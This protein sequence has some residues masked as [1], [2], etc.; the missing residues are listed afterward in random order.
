VVWAPVVT[1]IG[2]SVLLAEVVP[3]LPWLYFVLWGAGVLLLL[4]YVPMALINPT[5]GLH[6]G[7]AGTYLVPD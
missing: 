6:D 2:L 3:S 7:I 4:L 1:L 5:R